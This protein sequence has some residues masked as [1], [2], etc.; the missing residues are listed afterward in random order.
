MSF[1][2]AGSVDILKVEYSRE[3][4]YNPPGFLGAVL[5][6]R[7]HS[8]ENV[9]LTTELRMSGRD[10]AAILSHIQSMTFLHIKFYEGN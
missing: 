9:V 8:S 6:Q 2:G 5:E 4:Q 7:M 3:L 1:A 10:S